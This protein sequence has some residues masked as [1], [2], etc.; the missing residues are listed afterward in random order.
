CNSINQETL[1]VFIKDYTKAIIEV[2]QNQFLHSDLY[3]ALSIFNIKLFPKSEKQITTYG[4]K[5]IE[6]LDNYYENS[7]VANYN[8]FTG[9]IDKEKL[10][11]E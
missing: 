2:L 10:L 1:F 8:I 3:N 5:E 11:E 6:F 9:I 4:Q 7:R